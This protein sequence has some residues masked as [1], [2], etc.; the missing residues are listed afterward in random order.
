MKLFKTSQI[1]QIDLLTIDYEPISSIDLMERAA[2]QLYGWCAQN[3]GT[4]AKVAV[5][6][7]AG[8]NGGDG[9][10]L[11]RMLHCNGYWVE[12][13]YIEDDKPSEDFKQNLSRLLGLNVQVTGIR[14]HSQL[15]HIDS[16]CVVVDAI[17]GSG[18]SRPVTGLYA[19][20]IDHINS[21]GAK[22]IAIDIPSGLLGEEN[23]HPNTNTVVRADICLT[24]EQPKLSLLLAENEPFVK[25]WIIIPIGISTRAKAET[26]T[27]FSLTE[28][29]DISTMLQKRSKFSHKGSYG[30][31][32]IIGGSYGMMGATTL[33]TKAALNSGVGLTT[34][35]IPQ[36]GFGILQQALPEAMVSVDCAER[37][38]TA[39]GSV[40][41]YTAICIGPGLGADAQT[42]LALEDVLRRAKAPLVLDADALNI[43]AQQPSLWEVVP[44]STIITPHP[45]EFDRLFGA[46]P[47]GY[48]RLMKAREMAKKHEII[49]VLKGAYTQV[50]SPNGDVGFNPTGNPGMATGGSGDV[51]AGLIVGLLAQGYS[52]THASIL[53][54]YL[55]G[56]SGDLATEK[57]GQNALKSGDI[58]NFVPMVFR[59][60][61]L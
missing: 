29:S 36:C 56:L 15:P 48:Q 55:H 12:V 24:L 50:I 6:C 60:F 23:P 58:A 18:L 9:L 1:K 40:D 53:G 59:Q 31:A 43:I 4:S 13:F 38:F 57:M 54:V 34:A 28:V 52:P 35:H 33:C 47:T 8:N 45:K 2:Q 5:V 7:G 30:H 61:G 27:P 42:A 25:E 10:A 16:T 3:I 19:Q 44:A 21:S 14:S 26:P 37:K 20:T 17:F 41:R 39:V 11:A 46:S 49:I 32:L 22:V 51:L